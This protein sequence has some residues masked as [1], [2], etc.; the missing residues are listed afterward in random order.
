VGRER[1]GWRSR[2][3]CGGGIEEVMEARRS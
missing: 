2:D 1:G 3:V